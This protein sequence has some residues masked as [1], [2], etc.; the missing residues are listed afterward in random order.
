MKK[1]EIQILIV[2]DDSSLGKSLEELI[3]KMGYKASLVN[4]ADDAINFVKIKPVHMAIIDCMLPK[5]NGIDLVPQIRDSR[6]GDGPVVLMSGIFKDKSFAAEAIKKTGAIEFL[7]KP[8]ETREMRSLI[9]KA[10]GSQ[11]SNADV[12]LNT[13]VSL[14]TSSAREQLKAVEV[15][16]ELKGTELPVI[17]SV[18]MSVEFNGHLNLANNNGGIFGITFN[19]GQIVKFDGPDSKSL[20]ESI[21]ASK[22]ILSAEEMRE[23]KT[24]KTKGDLLINLVEENLLSPHF[25]PTIKNEQVVSELRALLKEETV[26]L[27]LVPDRARETGSEIK[28]NEMLPLFE[29]CVQTLDVG[30]LKD[31]YQQW[32]SFPIRKS[33]DYNDAHP[34]LKSMLLKKVPGAQQLIEGDKTLQ[35]VLTEVGDNQ[36][37]FY[38]VL[39]YLTL[40]RITYFDDVKA[41]QGIEEQSRRMQKILSDIQGKGHDEI[42]KYFGASPA[43]KNQEIEKIYKE[44][45]KSNHPDSIPPGAPEDFKTAV[46]TVF[47]MV[48]AAHDILTDDHKREDFF[49]KLKQQEATKQMQAESH[50]EE[51]LNHLRKGRVGVALPKLKS[52]YEIFPNSNHLIYLC[53]GELKAMGDLV[54]PN[55]INEVAKHLDSI[56]LEDRR[57]PYFQLVNGLLKKAEGDLEGAY[58]HFDKALALDAA[59]LDAR[60]EISN[61]ATSKKTGKKGTAISDITNTLSSLFKK[62]AD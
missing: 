24:K 13:F 31:F 49:S 44:F 57:T 29:E 32:M 35:E 61:L 14:R 53:W 38:R 26:K 21:L 25:I 55:K 56:P 36:E 40:A 54:N 15:I 43:L 19:K 62:K 50:A 58:T 3:K 4:K 17:L 41:V 1:N 60:R 10:V 23:F 6:F 39:H 45:V 37:S 18:L 47:Q 59:F 51:G 30:F 11:V 22:E 7:T 34:A 28:L 12:T 16:E 2:E 9:E 33:P 46:T 52:A 20:T 27:N 5:M 42:F 48:S 8:F